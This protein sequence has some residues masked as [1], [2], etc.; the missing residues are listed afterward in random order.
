MLLKLSKEELIRLFILY[1]MLQ[2]MYNLNQILM[3]KIMA[4]MLVASMILVASCLESEEVTPN[5]ISIESNARLEHN[6]NSGGG[7][8]DP[9]PPGP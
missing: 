4:M 1:F 6:G 2:S 5:S 9:I 7:G 3:K 8:D